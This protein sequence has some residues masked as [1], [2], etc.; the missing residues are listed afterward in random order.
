MLL[1]MVEYSY[2][3]LKQ[4]YYWKPVR[5]YNS[6]MFL[7]IFV[8]N[9]TEAVLETSSETNFLLLRNMITEYIH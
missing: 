2:N 7:L 1:P 8:A 9:M 4:R 5:S 6:E 3:R